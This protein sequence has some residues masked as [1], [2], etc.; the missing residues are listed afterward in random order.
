M[1]ESTDGSGSKLGER[2]R[3]VADAQRD[4]L[5]KKIGSVA[6]AFHGTSRQL[7]GAGEESAAEIAGRIGTRIERVEHFLSEHDAKDLVGSAERFARREP[8]LF[9]GVAF[10]AGVLAAELLRHF[11]SSAPVAPKD[12][13]IG[14]GAH[15]DGGRHV[16]S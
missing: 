1:D 16:G 4:R 8:L 7:R 6:S 10:A 14:D 15:H 2:A 5:T 9:L 11:G 3:G 13:R 12:K